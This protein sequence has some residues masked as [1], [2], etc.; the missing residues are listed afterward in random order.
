M[1]NHPLIT[2]IYRKL[3]VKRRK[4]INT[5]NPLIYQYQKIAHQS[6]TGYGLAYRLLGIPNKPQ[7]RFHHVSMTKQLSAWRLNW[8]KA[9]D[10]HSRTLH[11]LMDKP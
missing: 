7:T 3:Q 6:I 5:M 2:Y 1:T 11:R 8:V 10:E 4:K 9:W